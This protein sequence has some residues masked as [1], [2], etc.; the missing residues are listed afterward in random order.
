MEDYNFLKMRSRAHDCQI[1]AIGLVLAT[2]ANR[3]NELVELAEMHSEMVK[4]VFTGK[5]L[6]EH[7]GQAKEPK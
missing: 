4:V 2:M 6:Q 1:E 3:L 5:P 7:D